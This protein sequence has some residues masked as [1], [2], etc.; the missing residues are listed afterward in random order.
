MDTVTAFKISSGQHEQFELID[1]QPFSPEKYTERQIAILGKMNSG[2]ATLRQKRTSY[3]AYV[4]KD[5]SF[6][7][8]SK[9]AK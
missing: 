8:A 5:G 6:G 4:K 2:I 1:L 7:S 3:T 9:V